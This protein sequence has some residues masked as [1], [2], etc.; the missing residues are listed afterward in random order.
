M[1]ARRLRRSLVAL[2]GAAALWVA[3]P[4]HAVRAAPFR[5]AGDAPRGDA[6]A[7]ETALERARATALQTALESLSRPLR[8][9]ADREIL[10]AAAAWTRAY[11]VLSWHDDG[12]TLTVEVEVEI[13]VPRLLKR[14]TVPDAT[15]VALPRLGA[16][17]VTRGCT[18]VGV[19]PEDVK[20]QL[21]A[22]GVLAA[23]GDGE[24]VG[25]S[26]A[27][28]ALGP[29]S[30]TLLVGSQ[31]EVRVSRPGG[32]A[33][34]VSADA[35]AGDP[36]QAALAALQEAVSIWSRR[37]TARPG[38]VPMRLVVPTR[39][40]W[41]RRF[42]SAMARAVV[43]VERVDLHGVD[44]DGSIALRAVGQLDARTLAGRI[45]TLQVPGVSVRI[46]EVRD[47]GILEIEL[48]P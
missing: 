32:R 37:P 45:R 21:L 34:A 25:F 2:A 18:A 22:T 13:D 30:H 29:V 16:V 8:P 4:P 46:A 5:G 1:R 24:A 33:L 10:D 40:A 38:E 27:C 17:Q 31:V 35:F 36:A 15:P 14:A 23:R 39:A 12:A 11:R 6:Q 20:A 48:G 47:D 9:G 19:Q 28:R 42:R 44:A 43:G 3:T 41:V 7:R 26:V